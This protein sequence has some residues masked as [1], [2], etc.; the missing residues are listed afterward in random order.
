MTKKRILFFTFLICA[1]VAATAIIGTVKSDY[2]TTYPKNWSI[3]IPFNAYCNEVYAKDSGSSFHG[4]GLRYHVYTYQDGAYIE[5][6]LKWSDTEG[7]T[8]WSG[9]YSE[10]ADA[11]LAELEASSEFYP[12]YASCVYSYRVQEDNSELIAI[13]DETAGMLYMLESFL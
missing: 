10:A 1:V 9:S 8:L 11:W 6:M 13:W 12:D 5:K 3:A 2:T 7:E 4:D